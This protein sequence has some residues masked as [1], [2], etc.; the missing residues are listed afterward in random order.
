LELLIW[1]VDEDEED[2]LNLWTL[3][4]LAVQFFG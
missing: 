2:G 3:G 1:S 4:L